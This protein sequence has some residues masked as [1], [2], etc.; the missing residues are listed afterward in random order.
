MFIFPRDPSVWVIVV[1]L[2]LVVISEKIN[3]L[4]KMRRMS[5]DTCSHY[6]LIGYG[7]TTNQIKSIILAW[8]DGAIITSRNK[9]W[10]S[11]EY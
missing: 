9:T 1:N 4:L 10:G 2:F 3:R 7:G 8:G 5:W 6:E 11:P